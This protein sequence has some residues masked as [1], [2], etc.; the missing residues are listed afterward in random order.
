MGHTQ[1]SLIED[2][3]KYCAT[4][5][6]PHRSADELVVGLRQQHHD[7]GCHIEWLNHF[8]MSWENVVTPD[9]PDVAE[10]A[11]E[12]ARQLYLNIGIVGVGKIIAKHRNDPN[13]YAT[14][15]ASHEYCDSNMVMLAAWCAL[16]GISEEDFSPSA[17][18]QAQDDVWQAAWTL[19]KKQE[20]KR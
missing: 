13:T 17:M 12:F 8:V 4:H 14:C 5:K 9:L 16:I 19:A 11:Q 7:I 15:C 18:S 20:F 3:R 1:E 2:L 6:L 10:L